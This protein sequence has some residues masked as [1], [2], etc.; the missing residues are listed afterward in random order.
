MLNQGIMNFNTIGVDIGK[1]NRAGKR[2]VLT[3]C[4]V[5]CR[6]LIRD[7]G[8]GTFMNPISPE[9]VNGINPDDGEFVT[10]IIHY[11]S[12]HYRNVHFLQQ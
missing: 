1:V 4:G 6:D 7:R 9:K 2:F 12:E 10:F 11:I 8:N 5:G 3:R